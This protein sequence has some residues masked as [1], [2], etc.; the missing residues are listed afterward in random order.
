MG[1]ARLCSAAG[2][3]SEPRAGQP[4]VPGQCGQHSKAWFALV[5]HSSSFQFSLVVRSLPTPEQSTR[6]SVAERRMK[7]ALQE[8]GVTHSYTHTHLPCVLPQMKLLQAGS[9]QNLEALDC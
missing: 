6:G 1:D 4:E 2:A 3:C 7:V 9:S 5:Q 8:V